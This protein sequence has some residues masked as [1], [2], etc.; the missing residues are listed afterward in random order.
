MPSTEGYSECAWTKVRKSEGGFPRPR[1]G[2]RACTVNN[3]KDILILGGGNEGIIDG[4]NL[5]DTGLTFLKLL[6]VINFHN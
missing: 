1:H 2:H 3:G 4:I 6:P 5:Y